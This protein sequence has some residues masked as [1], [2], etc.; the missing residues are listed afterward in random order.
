M[1]NSFGTWDLVV[2]L[3]GASIQFKKMAVAVFDASL[4]V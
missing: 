4:E 2:R 1:G 3:F